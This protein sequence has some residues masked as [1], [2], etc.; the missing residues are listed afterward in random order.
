VCP[1]LT[2]LAFLYTND[3]HHLRDNKVLYRT[4][5]TTD[6][7]YLG[8]RYKKPGL[9]DMKLWLDMEIDD[10]ALLCSTG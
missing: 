1:L 3:I 7:L 9:T 10:I 2:L 5:V 8:I 6:V 4:I